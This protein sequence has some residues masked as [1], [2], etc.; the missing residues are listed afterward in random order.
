M[1]YPSYFIITLS[2]FIT[3][4]QCITYKDHL[5]SVK[6]STHSHCYTVNIT[7]EQTLPDSNELTNKQKQ[8]LVKEA[9]LFAWNGYHKHS[10]GYDEN[11]PVT[12]EP[13]NTRNGWGATIVD[14]LDTL[15]IM[16]LEKE[17]EQAKQYVAKINWDQVT[18]DVQVF[19]TV[20]RYVGGLIS[21]YELSDDKIFIDKCV[22]LVDRLLPAFDS[23]T[24]IPYRF[25]DFKTGKAVTS[26]NLNNLAEIG[27]LQLELTRLS[28]ITGNWKYHDIGQKVYENFKNI[29]TSYE[30][31]FPHLIDINTGKPA[32]D[33]YSFG[34][35]ADSFYE[36]LIKQYVL[37]NGKDE[38]KKEMMI[39]AARGL[40]KYLVQT[41]QRFNSNH[42]GKGDEEDNVD[43]SFKFIGSIYG[44]TPIASMGELACFA[45]GT[46][47]LAS[48]W[49]PELNK[50]DQIEDVAYD[51]L[52]GCYQAWISTR[53]GIAPE[54]FGWI[55][56]GGSPPTDLS[57]RQKELAN[58]FGVFP[59]GYPIYILRPETL[60][61]IYYFY[62]YK[63][64]PKYQDMAWTLFKSIDKYCKAN[65]GF[66]GIRDVDAKRPEWDDRQ[67]SFMFA[68]TFK[69]LY[70]I[71]DE[72]PRFPFDQWVFN[73]EAH[74]FRIADIQPPP[75]SS[76]SFNIQY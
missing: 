56:K 24:H 43:H 31:L 61:S 5:Q 26:D 33:F 50:E 45:P 25:V 58:Q 18:D 72:Q 8:D 49:I 30:G 59:L 75:S 68:E 9:F 29:K 17:F 23:P 34:G 52:L 22:E 36:Y 39:K 44:H 11:R 3:Y 70:L 7:K 67:E 53:T 10:W 12:N 28:Q 20:I 74:P 6:E 41:P 48:H 37:S 71:W 65:S 60:E 2:Y 15:Y 19:E 42:L 51:T 66:S 13:L 21:A 62:V 57:D 54:G 46:L 63:K 35:M 40:K 64:N 38:E 16:G 55:P 27:T 73:T 32:S 14:A 1:K 4:I 47:L 76:L 69:Y